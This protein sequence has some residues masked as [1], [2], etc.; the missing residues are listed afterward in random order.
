MR[1][2]L[3]KRLYSGELSTWEEFNADHDF[4]ELRKKVDDNYEQ[5]FAEAYA[6][7]LKGD[8]AVAGGIIEKLV[9]IRPNDGPTKNLNKVI[10]ERGNKKAPPNWRGVRELTSK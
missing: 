9:S 5:L 3:I 4:R 10:N 2:D 6:S 8:W 1:T 7:Y